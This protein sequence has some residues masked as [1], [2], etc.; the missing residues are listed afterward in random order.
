MR[1]EDIRDALN[2]R[3]ACKL[4]D[5]SKKI[6]EADFDL[7]LEAGR[8]APSSM[9]IEPWKFVVLQNEKIRQE[10]AN[11]SWGGKK[12]IPSASHVVLILSRKADDLKYDS[13]YINDLLINTKKLPDDVVEIMKKIMKDIEDSRFQNKDDLIEH[14]SK[15]QA[16][17]AM[18]D[19]MQTAALM[20]IDSCPI[21]GFDK[22]A[23]EKILIENNILDPKHF[24]LALITA[25]GYR[26]EEPAPK[27]RRAKE[28]VIEW[29]K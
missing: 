19:M 3:Y 15:E 18:A 14:Y 29:V 28:Q 20:R 8:L 24:E 5:E 12:Q 11:V 13:E 6:N 27:T 9:G 2:F 22:E 1:R 23:V 7:I 4:F 16:H 21:G 26:G 17:I 25:F 10:V